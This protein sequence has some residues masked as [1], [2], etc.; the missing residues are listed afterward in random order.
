MSLAVRALTV[1]VLVLG[2]V[3][4]VP[5]AAAAPP[6]TITASAS[7]GELTI[8]AMT[9]VSGRLSAAG[10]GVAGVALT[11]QAAPY[12]LHAFTPLAR[13]VSGADGSFTFTG[14]RPDRNTTLRVVSE[15]GQPTAVVGPP[16]AVIVDPVVYLR[17]RRLG[18]GQTQLAMRM[19][20]AVVGAAASVSAWWYVQAR[21]SRVFRLAAVTPTRELSRGLLYASATV[22][23]PSRRFAYRVCLNPPWESA[24]GASGAHG[25][26][27]QH[28][29]VLR[30][31]HG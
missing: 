11:L 8:G 6:T 12:P 13:V 19:R 23:P 30:G 22:D 31:G 3:G 20:H 21:G 26:C 2:G 7:P 16:L 14:V 5:A 18:P 29:F 17:A 9:G 4:M 24:M 27:P 25:R 10:A 28:D 15:E 1:A